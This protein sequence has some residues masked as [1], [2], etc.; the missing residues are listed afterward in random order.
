MVSQKYSSYDI[1]YNK[2]NKC[3]D[4]KLL[5][6]DYKD[7]EDQESKPSKDLNLEENTPSISSHASISINIPKTINI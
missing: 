4:K 2:G 6:I 1:N 3:S 7:E 5:C